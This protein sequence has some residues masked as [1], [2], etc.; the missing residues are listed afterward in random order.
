MEEQERY[1]QTSAE[2]KQEKHTSSDPPKHSKT[3]R[4]HVFHSLPPYTGPF[5][6]GYLEMELPVEQQSR[7]NFAP[8]AYKRR[9]KQAMQ[10]ETVLF[11]I[12]YPTTASTKKNRVGK[13][14]NP[15][16]TTTN[17][18]TSNKSSASTDSCS[19]GEEDTDEASP[20]ATSLRRVPWLPRPRVLTAHGYAR[21][22]GV[23]RGAVTAYMSSTCMWTKL[24]AARNARLAEERPPSSSPEPN[25][26]AKVE[27]GTNANSPKFPVVVF[28]HGLGGSRTMYSTICG[29]L[30][31]YGFVVVAMEHRD[32]SGARSYVN[33]PPGRER[34]S[35]GFSYRRSTSDSRKMSKGRRGK[36]AKDKPKGRPNYL[37]DYIF[38]KNNPKD[39]DPQNEKGPDHE[40]RYA[41][42]EMR[43]AE[44]EEAFKILK[45]INTGDPENKI[46]QLNLRK[47]PNRGSSSKGLDGIN[48]A[49][50][51]D[52][53]CLENVTAM[54]HSFGGATTVQVLRLQDR[55]PWVGQG[56]LLDT[57]GPATPEVNPRSLQTITKPLL[58][59]GSET[60]MHWEI[61][62]EKM[63][64]I[65]AEAKQ[66]S[67][68]LCWMIT[69]RGATHLSQTDFAVLYPRFM[70]V[71]IKTLINPLRGI[72]L[73]I[74]STLEFLK[75]ALPPAQTTAYDTSDWADEGL[76][77]SRHLPD[78]L[79]THDHK[80]DEKWTAA[81]LKVDHEFKRRTLLWWNEIWKGMG[82]GKVPED[83]PR[84][85][86]G[87]AL[88]GLGSWGPGEE[89]WVHMCPSKAEVKKHLGQKP[90][91]GHGEEPYPIGSVTDGTV[92]GV[93]INPILSPS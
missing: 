65:C 79:V 41:Q 77:R 3:W 50:W 85:V 82:K 28:S 24:P 70:S 43:I 29:D 60:F 54:G 91:D 81:R 12:Y 30:A 11:A 68:G 32:G 45:L 2:D 52:R 25:R 78:S 42:I 48:W 51:K 26:V 16:A 34:K 7:T 90:E 47:K 53:L 73:N 19:K 92:S 87:R 44:I 59:I 13:N 89:I 35:S 17:V 10:L 76:L 31:S 27:A 83:V 21:F 61:N 88:F 46:K 55:F 8:P 33:I 37:V 23:P 80:P 84:D 14:E 86:D 9:N 39:T 74:A 22:L 40:L 56:V 75:I 62:Y 1:S 18:D 5:S 67:G 4:E 69:V 15:V 36:E 93:G 64:E 49:E 6:V 58:S 38:P 20:A 72:Y 63:A 71:F 57:W 66:G